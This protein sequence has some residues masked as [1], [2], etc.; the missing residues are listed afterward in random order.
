MNTLVKNY[1]FFAM[2]SIFVANLKFVVSL[3]LPQKYLSQ[4]INF[5]G[6]VCYK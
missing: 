3:F 6:N 5:S 2:T 1:C 4:N